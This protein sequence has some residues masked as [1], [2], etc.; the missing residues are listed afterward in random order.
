[1]ARVAGFAVDSLV[2]FR[3][4]AGV[5][6]A[7]DFEAV[8]RAVEAAFVAGVPVALFRVEGAVFDADLSAADFEVVWRAVGAAFV[9][10]V[11]VALFRVEGAV[12]D[13][14]FFAADFWVGFGADVEAT[15][16]VVMRAGD[17]LAC[18]AAVFWADFSVAASSDGS[19]SRATMLGDSATTFAC[20]DIRLAA[21]C[22]C[23]AADSATATASSRRRSSFLIRLSG[24][25]VDFA[26][27]TDCLFSDAFAFAIGFVLLLDFV[28]ALAMV[29]PRDRE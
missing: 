7:A 25:A 5:F 2:A 8:W 29:S 11:L 21:F 9:S 23:F 22:V 27:A 4:V 17:F 12:F 19:T 13:A 15:L 24:L 3:D 1:V 16:E 20:L 6:F 18:F 26:L 10:D 14:D 28:L